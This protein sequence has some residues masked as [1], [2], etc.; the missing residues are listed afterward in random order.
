MYEGGGEERER[1]REGGGGRERERES[2]R[3]R[4]GEG[5]ERELK[6]NHSRVLLLNLQY[7]YEDSN[8]SCDQHDICINCNRV[9]HPLHCLVK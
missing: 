3:V 7:I 2:E 8:A 9:D 6:N 5:G 4:E 1:E